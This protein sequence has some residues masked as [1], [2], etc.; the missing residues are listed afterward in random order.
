MMLPGS[1][2]KK[3]VG[4]FIGLIVCAA[5][6][7]YLASAYQ[8]QDV[9]PALGAVQYQLL[10]VQIWGVHFCYIC[11]R[12]WRLYLLVRRINPEISFA[13]LYIITAIVVSLAILTPGQLG[14]LLK[15]EVLKRRNLLNRLP[16]LGSL[17]AER[18]ADLLVVAGIACTGFFFADNIT[19]RYPVLAVGGGLCCVGLVVFFVLLHYLSRGK[20]SSWW[21]QLRSG[22]IAPGLWVK[23]LVLTM[24]SWGCV[25]WGWSL[26][27][28][29]VQVHLALWELVWLLSLVT[30]G[31]IVSLVPGGFGVAEV[32]TVEL[33]IELGVAPVAAQA[34]A[35]LLRMYGFILVFF[36]L[37]HI[38]YCGFVIFLKKYKDKP[39]Q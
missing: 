1:F 8:W 25:A 26:I 5:S 9:F 2:R 19:R 7:W 17:I 28:A 36:G 11:L 6:L 16:G 13:D 3:Y 24:L 30:I 32:L 39:R 23:T 34:G 22:Y 37:L 4:T 33:L 27:L 14:E 12:T 18:F 35:L 15:V 20:Q 38:L 21:S 29:A 10:I 31:T